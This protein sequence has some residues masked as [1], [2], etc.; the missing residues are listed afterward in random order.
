MVIYKYHPVVRSSIN[1][2][3]D[4]FIFI[5]HYIYIMSDIQSLHSDQA[6]CEHDEYI[7]WG[8]M[9]IFSLFTE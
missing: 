9:F 5:L 3:F 6:A 8:T 7:F 2:Y 1:Q 4:V